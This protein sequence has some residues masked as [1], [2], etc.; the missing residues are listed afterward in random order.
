[1]HHCCG[2]EVVDFL[3]FNSKQT[4]VAVFIV[5]ISLA[6]TLW[7]SLLFHRKNVPNK[8]TSSTTSDPP[9]KEEP[10]LTRH[11]T[12]HLGKASSQISPKI[13]MHLQNLGL[14]NH[15]P[16]SS[17][18]TLTTTTTKIT[19]VSFQSHLWFFCFWKNLLYGCFYV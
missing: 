3:Y 8:E 18:P 17:P 2:K 14:L 12:Q 11:C 1:M 6:L 19:F 15:H 4:L 10:S 16:N 9:T 5:K 7:V 13:Q